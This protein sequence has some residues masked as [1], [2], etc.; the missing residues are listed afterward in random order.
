MS[1]CTAMKKTEHQY[2]NNKN[3]LA[4]TC[5]HAGRRQCILFQASV[6]SAI[7]YLNTAESISAA[8]QRHFASK[9][10]IDIKQISKLQDGR[11]TP[12]YGR[13]DS[14]PPVAD[15]STTGVI[16]RPTIINSSLSNSNFFNFF[17]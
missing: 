8:C 1:Q 16:K 15:I 6:T 17:Y 2:S 10:N 3:R 13:T 11:Q 9:L 4:P 7:G 12:P 5:C 14:N